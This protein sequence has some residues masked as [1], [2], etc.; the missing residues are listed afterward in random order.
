M[1]PKVIQGGMGI[2]VSNWTL[3]RAVSMAGQL[4]VISGTAIDTIMV[5]RLQDGDEG[6]DVRR[7][8]SFFPDQAVVKELLDKFFNP[9]GRRALKPYR[10][11]P[12][13]QTVSQKTREMISVVG[14]FVETFLAKEGHN[15][16]V[17]MN[18]LTKIQVPTVSTIYG[19][20]LAG[21]DYLLIG[22]GIPREI[23]KILDD[24]IG[25]REASLKLDVEGEGAA[26]ERVYFNPAHHFETPPIEIKRPKF[27]PIVSTH[28]LAIM[29]LKKLKDGVDGF[30]VENAV[31][32]G[33]NAPP[34]EHK[35]NALGEPEYG[36]RDEADLT[37]MREL[38]KPFWIA[39][40]MGNKHALDTALEAGASGVQVG[41]L[42]AL[43]NESGILPTIRGKIIEKIREGSAKVF[44]DPLAS[45]TG[46]PFKI[47]Q[48]EGTASEL[49]V[50]EDRERVC[51]V[52]LLRTAFHK[53]DGSV[54]FR[55]PGE[56]ITEFVKKGGVEQ[57]AVGRKCICNGL[58]AT[59]GL[60]QSNRDGVEEPALITSGS[61][62]DDV[63]ELAT[64]LGGEY[65]AKDA[66]EYILNG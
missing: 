13:Y 48:L 65:S 55:C 44:T 12:L 11:L 57:E 31:A 63:N 36:E 7:A 40:A 22:A 60:G 26:D 49:K 14:A 21:I 64:R 45:P 28:T 9:E 4:G 59:V 16:V 18:L 32:G 37:K 43:S 27:L 42:F 2:G 38:G 50:Y 24:L 54:G 51:D 29:L 3:A 6:G 46:F 1:F 52:G 41:T 53:E 56:P 23:P 5:R 10:V 25:H 8:L 19:A 35:F 15:G 58:L 20:L 47:F 33:H 34:R 62:F 30:I 17:G 39:G 61:N 66:V